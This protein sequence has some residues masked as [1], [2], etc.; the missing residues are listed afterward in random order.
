M[1]RIGG[2][3]AAVA[4]LSGPGYVRGFVYSADVV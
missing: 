2:I 1:P 3:S 4:A